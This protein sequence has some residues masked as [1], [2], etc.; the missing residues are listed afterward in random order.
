[1]TR[2][3]GIVIP[4]SRNVRSRYDRCYPKVGGTNNNSPRTSKSV[5]HLEHRVA[6]PQDQTFPP[7]SPQ[8]HKIRL[9]PRTTPP[10]IRHS[11]RQAYR[12]TNEAAPKS[13]SRAIVHHQTVTSSSRYFPPQ[14]PELSTPLQ[15]KERQRPPNLKRGLAIPTFRRRLLP[16]ELSRRGSYVGPGRH[17]LYGLT[18]LR[19]TTC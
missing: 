19:A 3:G 8:S 4:L 17:A 2:C 13:Q 9:I 5:C 16:F 11:R 7:C 18:P 12:Y 6:T 14:H 10:R 1:M 15:S